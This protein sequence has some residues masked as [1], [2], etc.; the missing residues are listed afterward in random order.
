MANNTQ[1]HAELFRHVLKS[2]KHDSRYNIFCQFVAR[3]VYSELI[4]IVLELRD[5]LS[6]IHFDLL[7]L[8]IVVIQELFNLE[9]SFSILRVVYTFPT[10]VIYSPLYIIFVTIGYWETTVIHFEL[11]AAFLPMRIV[12]YL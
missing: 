4:C 10:V 3:V 7:S 6:H 2:P 8:Q 9:I 11:S 12:I 5:S 1:L